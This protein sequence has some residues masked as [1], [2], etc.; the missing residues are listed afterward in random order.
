MGGM[1]TAL[2]LARQGFT[3]INVWEQAPYLD[4]VGAGINI[5]PN[6]GR[7]LT[8][9]GVMDICKAEGV[10]IQ[11]ANV[12]DCETD[13]V[14]TATNYS[15]YMRQEYGHPFITVHRSA[16]QKSLVRGA[17]DTGRVTLHLDQVISEYDFENTRLLVRD[18]EVDLDEDG[19]PVE[20][21]LVWI[22]AD[23]IICADGI[24]SKARAAL[25]EQQGIKDEV[26]STGQAAYRIMVRKSLA[27]NDPELLPFFTEA[28]SHRWIGER[29]HVMGYPIEAGDLFNI[30]TSQPDGNFVEE[31]EWTAM[32]DKDTMLETFADFCPRVKKLLSLVPQYEVLE[33]RLRVHKPL[34]SWVDGHLALVG[35]ACHPTLPH[36]A[37]GAAQ[38]IEDAVALGIILSRIKSKDQIPAALK[39]YQ[40]IRKPRADWAVHTADENSKHLHLKREDRDAWVADLRAALPE[41][42]ENV[43]IDRLGSRDTH[44]RLFRYDIALETE[45]QFSK[46]FAEELMAGEA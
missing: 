39:V 42:E 34:P 29:R 37:Q 33:W 32:G 40:K 3:N 23:L 41:G 36:L 11:V 7:I 10:A 46:L 27:A 16:L 45:Q 15:D 19:Y 2:S 4:E 30:S 17:L 20:G 35:D 22:D 12:H 18:D 21:E 8:R 6:L 44:D 5:P 13:E 1:G 31:D 26:E 38:A 14:L 43:V 9:W 25:L 24:K 28:Q